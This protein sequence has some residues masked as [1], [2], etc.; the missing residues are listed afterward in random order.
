MKGTVILSLSLDVLAIV[1]LLVPDEKYAPLSRDPKWVRNGK[2]IV[3]LV[4][5]VAGFLIDRYITHRG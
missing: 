5:L 2:R 1:V 4:L 3:F